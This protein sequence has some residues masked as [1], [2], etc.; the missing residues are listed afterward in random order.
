[1]ASNFIVE[2][3]EKLMQD[4]PILNKKNYN[5]KQFNEVNSTAINQLERIV[6]KMSDIFPTK[7]QTRIK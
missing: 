6:E 3:S 4:I 5:I 1:M 2:F 7:F